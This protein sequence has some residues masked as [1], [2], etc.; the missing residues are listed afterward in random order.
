MMINSEVS[1][2]RLPN[3]FQEVEWIGTPASGGNPY[4][5]TGI[6]AN[7]TVFRAAAKYIQTAAGDYYGLGARLGDGSTNQCCFFGFYNNTSEFAWRGWF[8]GPQAFLN[9]I[10]EVDAV[11]QNGSQNVLFD[12]TEYTYTKTGNFNGTINFFIFCRNHGN[13]TYGMYAKGMRYYYLKM[14]LDDVLV[15]DYIPCYRKSDG[16]IGM[17]DIVS[18]SFFTNAGSGTFEKGDDV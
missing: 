18:N 4:I 9:Q 5:D 11:M 6:V 1:G 15:R 14:W 8:Y 13:G 2:S 12:G 3:A 10:H 17:Y 16:E 7:A